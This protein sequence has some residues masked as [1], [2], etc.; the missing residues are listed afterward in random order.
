[1]RAGQHRGYKAPESSGRGTLRA[2]AQ[3]PRSRIWALGF[4]LLLILFLARPV[5]G[6][7]GEPAAGPL[8]F[9][10]CVKLALR[11][12]PVLLKSALEIEVRR[13]DEADSK[14]DFIPAFKFKTRF[15][16]SMPREAWRLDP[17]EYSVSFTSEDYNPLFAYFSLK[18]KKLITQAAI[19]GHLKVIAAS[20]HRLGQ[21]FLELEATERL[22]GLQKELARLARDNLRYAQERLKLGEVSPL[23]VRI[24]A[25]EVEVLA[26]EQDRL[27]ASQEKLRESLRT[28]L[29]LDPQQ[30]LELDLKQARRQLLGDFDPSR[31]S[32]EEA[33]SRAFDL[34]IQKLVQELQRWNIT[35]AKMRFLPSVNLAV[36]TAE[37][38][39]LPGIRGYFFSIGLSF[40]LFDG[41]KRLRNVSRQKTLLKQAEAEVAVKEGDHLQLW[42]EAQ[43]K[44]RGAAQALRLARAQEELARLK[45]RQA[46][47]LYRG[48]EPLPVVLAARQARSKAQV[49]VVQKTLD[50]DLAL[51]GLR[52][53]SGD[54]VYRYVHEDQ[55]RPEP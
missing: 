49:Q 11:Q 40:P 21:G 3:R 35:L 45:E 27:A 33:E 52:H 36:Q 7:N 47:T 9:D 42:R 19:L 48:G 18:V 54:L 51:L 5:P 31:A 12:S 53:L 14:S 38:V 13:L 16:V 28:F 37:P 34:R 26:A 10:A 43:D 22:E 8:D 17:Q 30:P 46:E 2:K 39:N 23:E 1:M 50:Y 41:L 6:G 25:Q 20:L 24:A 15:Y 29:A 4:G 55:F 44:L 32:R